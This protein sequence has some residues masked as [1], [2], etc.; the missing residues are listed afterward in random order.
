LCKREKLK[1]VGEQIT[2][3][4]CGP[5]QAQFALGYSEGTFCGFDYF[6]EKKFFTEFQQ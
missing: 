2:A 5:Y 1:I 6:V 4:K 3:I